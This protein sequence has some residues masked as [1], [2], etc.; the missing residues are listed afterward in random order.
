MAKSLESLERVCQI[1]QSKE[2]KR[3][4]GSSPGY[5]K[6]SF[7]VK[8]SQMYVILLCLTWKERTPNYTDWS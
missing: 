1:L 8:N 7:L 2:G 3:Q 5:A 6:A 4:V